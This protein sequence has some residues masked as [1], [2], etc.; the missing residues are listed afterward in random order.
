MLTASGG[1]RV[2]PGAGRQKAAQKSGQGKIIDRIV[3]AWN[4]AV[5][6]LCAPFLGSGENPGIRATG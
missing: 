6:L 3:F 2:D 1:P 5:S 4:R